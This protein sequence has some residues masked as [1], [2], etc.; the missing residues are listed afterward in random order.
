MNFAF[1]G[2]FESRFREMAT[3]SC[4][5]A[6]LD[7]TLSYVRNIYGSDKCFRLAAYSAKVAGE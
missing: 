7:K 1:F 4:S 5:L 3:P 2:R 6:Q